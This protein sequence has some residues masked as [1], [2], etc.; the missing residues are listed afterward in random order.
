LDRDIAAWG[1]ALGLFVEAAE[2]RSCH[3]EGGRW[4]G[5]SAED[6]AEAC[7]DGKVENLVIG[8]REKIVHFFD[9]AGGQGGDAK[10]EK[11]VEDGGE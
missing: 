6:K 9:S 1:E 11:I 5:K 7:V 10:D 8:Q 2:E 4:E 3:T